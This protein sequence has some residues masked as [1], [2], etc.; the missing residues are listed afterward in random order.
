MK[1][2]H[3]AVLKALGLTKDDRV[4]IIVENKI[5]AD[6]LAKQIENV[7]LK[8]LTMMPILSVVERPSRL[9]KPNVREIDDRNPSVFV[10]KR[11]AAK[12]KKAGKPNKR[13]I[14]AKARWAREK[15]AKG[16]KP[17]T[18]KAAKKKKAAK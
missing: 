14:A 1:K 5:V 6:I 12:A 7:C 11:R 16:K 9:P 8:F 2:S 3:A 15:A 18:K 4:Q 13:S 10:G 17:K